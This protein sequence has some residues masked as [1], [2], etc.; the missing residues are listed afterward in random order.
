MDPINKIVPLHGEG[1]YS[2]LFETVTKKYQISIQSLSKITGI[3]EEVIV[4]QEYNHELTEL[5]HLLVMLTTGMEQVDENDRVKAIIEVLYH[6]YHITGETIALYSKVELEDVVLFLKGDY[7]S[8]P[9]EKRY[10]IAVTT[11]F[12]HYLFKPAITARA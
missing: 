12:M 8:I 5:K 7:H 1:E 2:A 3:D 4:E 9:F 11:I 10:R 6:V